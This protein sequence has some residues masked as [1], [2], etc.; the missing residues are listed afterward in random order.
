M[1]TPEIEN[2]VITLKNLERTINNMQKVF[3]P[4]G[5]K[6]KIINTTVSKEEP[7][8]QTVGD[9]WFVESERN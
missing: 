4:I 6:N 7:V 1:M 3:A 5:V 9:I 8:N 2:T